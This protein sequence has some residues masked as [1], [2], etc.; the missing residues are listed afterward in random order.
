[1]RFQTT[2]SDDVIEGTQRKAITSTRESNL[3]HRVIRGRCSSQAFGSRVQRSIDERRCY[4]KTVFTG[5]SV[6]SK[7]RNPTPSQVWSGILPS[8]LTHLD[9]L[10][11][12]CETRYVSETTFKQRKEEDWR[13]Q[14][15]TSIVFCLHASNRRHYEVHNMVR[16][17]VALVKRFLSP[18]L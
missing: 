1:M 5:G 9:M 15:P 13:T 8:P 11:D 16:G 7:T 18:H 3:G 2:T 12:V 17:G 14:L 6:L 10:M 4:V